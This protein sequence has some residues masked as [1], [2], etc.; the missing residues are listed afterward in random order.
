M[1]YAGR[2]VPAMYKNKAFIS[3]RHTPGDMATA[4]L[5]QKKLE[6]YRIPRE[7]ASAKGME[8]VGR[9]FLDQTDL[10]GKPNLTEELQK[11]LDSSEFLIVICSP[12]TCGSR[13][14]KEE[15][16]YF[17]EHHQTSELL[18]VISAGD[19]QKVLSSIFRGIDGLPP[20]M[21]ACDFSG[22]RWRVIREEI[23]RLAS[24][25]IGCGYDDLVRRDRQFRKK[26][27]LAGA[28]VALCLVSG[29]AAYHSFSSARIKKS[30]L[31][32]LA[33]EAQRLAGESESALEKRERFDA[34]RYA[35]QAFP[36]GDEEPAAGEAV[37]SLQKAVGAYVTEGRK[38]FA[39][40]DEF[41]VD[42]MIDD[43][44]CA[45]TENGTY[46]AIQYEDYGQYAL[47]VWDVA[48][49]KQ[50]FD[51]KAG[52][53]FPSESGGDA[54]ST[55]SIGMEMGN[56]SLL[57][58]TK[59]IF[60][61]SGA[62]IASI[63]PQ[64]GRTI[65]ME[66]AENTF[67]QTVLA[68]NE[69]VI[70]ILSLSY[71]EKNRGSTEMLQLR[72]AADGSL[73]LHDVLNTSVGDAVEQGKGY[74]EYPKALFSDDGQSLVLEA[75]NHFYEADDEDSCLLYSI[76]LST[77][78]KSL[79]IQEKEILDFCLP[80]NKSIV[81]AAADNK[82]PGDASGDICLKSINS[83][84]GD[85]AWSGAGAGPA[86]DFVCLIPGRDIILLTGLHAVIYSSESG[87]K[88]GEMVFPEPAA[89]AFSRTRQEDMPLLEVVS[90]EGALFIWNYAKGETSFYDSVFPAAVSRAGK[91]DDSFLL[92]CPDDS[93][94]APQERIMLFR[95]EMWD[96]ELIKVSIPDEGKAPPDCSFTAVPAEGR[97]VLVGES[98]NAF[99]IDAGTGKLLWS[100]FIADE[101]EQAGISEQEGILLFS[102]FPGLPGAD[103]ASEG[104][105]AVLDMMTGNVSRVS[106]PA[107][108][109][110][111][112]TGHIE[113]CSST[114]AGC[115]LESVVCIH[116]APRGTD[117]DKRICIVRYSL[118][119][120]SLDMVDITGCINNG[121]EE[122][123]IFGNN[124]GENSLCICIDPST[125]N[126][127]QLINVDWRAKKA[128]PQKT[129]KDFS[130]NSSIPV[131]WNSDGT[132]LAV[133][134]NKGRI[135]LFG[136]SRAD[137]SP[138]SGI[139][140]HRN[141]AAHE[142]SRETDDW[143][144]YIAGFDFHNGSLATVEAQ[145]NRIW[146]RDV[147]EGISLPLPATLDNAND[148]QLIREMGGWAEVGI[149]D[150]WDK[151]LMLKYGDEAFL[152]DPVSESVEME[153]GGFLCFNPVS[154][155]LLLKD[156][157]GLYIARRYGLAD[158]VRKG[159]EILY[160]E[161]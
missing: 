144:S 3:Y 57:V 90:Q 131:K 133:V 121:E 37:Y 127:R 156:E 28:A 85:E 88:S 26:K 20:E 95:G 138:L 120:E 153:A 60:W 143:Q 83:Q 13:W 5:V 68:G 101:I 130:I 78:E 142:T 34:I 30:R 102:I 161:E 71:P 70:A 135:R 17:L 74:T 41:S 79:L 111:G 61:S 119:D 14:V 92:F 84:T 80:D 152:I 157:E 31:E 58:S 122:Y 4:Q 112:N 43:W 38:S 116:S 117:P 134:D 107:S 99:G 62:W 6:R 50:V 125:E 29:M 141:G 49:R 87:E 105:W 24:A 139:N 115:Y 39:Q 104:V 64:S 145:G 35:L 59:A 48:N 51:I 158:L 40:T 148:S 110:A 96:R 12:D 56:A 114:L 124:T 159:K 25:L 94:T 21:K 36:D 19:P 10:G 11:E 18:P 137:P 98:G 53:F 55:S 7:I 77:F 47:A 15:I 160:G 52:E 103:E 140:E 150:T 128:V 32:Q 67:Q 109:L 113:C 100:V 91:I 69:D 44:D 136:I 2:E 23:P 16:V 89:A 22:K 118:K 154:D 54:N 81:L 106:L 63:D 9:I 76:D 46:L 123:R 66:Q 65:W 42:G 1:P 129:G 27:A 33:S 149:A 146:F 147:E 72:H 126:V 108:E 97:F 75:D 155:T 93:Q 86:D 73:F 82:D 132:G 45:E 151:K 8:R